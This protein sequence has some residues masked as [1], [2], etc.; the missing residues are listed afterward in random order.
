MSGHLLYST[1]LQVVE[2]VVRV[3]FATDATENDT[4][5]RARGIGNPPGACGLFLRLAASWVYRT[6]EKM[7]A[8]F[9]LLACHGCTLGAFG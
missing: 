3:F 9:D 2:S 5:Q 8:C 1:R 7:L 6:A 4:G